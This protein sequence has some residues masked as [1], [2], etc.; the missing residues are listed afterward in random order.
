MRYNSAVIGAMLFAIEMLIRQAE[1]RVEPTD[2]RNAEDNAAAEFVENCRE[3]LD[4]PWN[5]FVVEIMSMLTFGWSLFEIIYQQRE[6]GRYGW[7]KFGMRAQETLLRWIFSDTGEP[8]AMVQLA[9][10]KYQ[11]TEIPLD[12]CLLF[13]T[14]TQK[15]NPEGLSVLR[16]A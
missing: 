5:D 12:R 9:P 14:T 13:R 8:L 6:D 11:S 15:N 2:P 1:W 10:P 7:K 3:N 16:N 4:H